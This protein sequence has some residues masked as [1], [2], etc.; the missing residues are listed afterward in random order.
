MPSARHTPGRP[1]LLGVA[2]A[3]RESAP[4]DVGRIDHLLE[5][6]RQRNE[7]L[8]VTG[9]LLYSGGCF[10]QYLEGPPAA[11]LATYEHIARDPGHHQLIELMHQP[12]PQRLFPDW[13]MAW[14]CTDLIGV[15]EPP[16]APGLL[17]GPGRAGQP[18]S[19]VLCLLAAFWNRRRSPVQPVAEV[20]GAAATSS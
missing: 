11:V 4:L 14:R 20:L 19:P 3:S 9:V 17:F 7:R 15:S 8:G 5:R 18:E 12:V 6:A 10:L 16:P 13:S 1:P 2:Y